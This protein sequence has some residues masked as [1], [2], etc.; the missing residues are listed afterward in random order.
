MTLGLTVHIDGPEL[1]LDE[2]LKGNGK[3]VIR[4]P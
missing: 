2:E 4:L 1:D 3:V